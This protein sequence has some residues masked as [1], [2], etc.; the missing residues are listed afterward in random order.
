MYTTNLSNVSYIIIFSD[1]LQMSKYAIKKLRMRVRSGSV[2]S[3]FM[4]ATHFSLIA[5]SDN[6][7][8]S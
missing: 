4:V 8:N 2:K 5:N 6:F 7:D 1:A 3:L